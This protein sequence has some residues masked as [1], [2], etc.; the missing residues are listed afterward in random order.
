GEILLVERGVDPA[1]GLLDT[2]GGFVDVGEN[3]GDGLMRELKEELGDGVKDLKYFGSFPGTYVFDRVKIV[4]IGLIYTG[5]IDDQKITPSDD[6]SG[7]KFFNPSQ[8]P[9]E[10]LAFIELEGAIKNYISTL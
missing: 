2:P 4:T 10:K 9:Y 7:Y 3:A 1:K 8:I 5:K 6:V